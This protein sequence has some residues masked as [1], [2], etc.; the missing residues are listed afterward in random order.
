MD[1]RG[2][3]EAL[4][5]LIEQDR[6]RRCDELTT[7]A[8]LEAAQTLREARAQARARVL[9]ALAQERYRLQDCHT[10]CEAA[11]ATETRLHEQRRFRTLL[12][13]ARQRLPQALADRWANAAGRSTWLKHVIDCARAALPVGPWLIA[14]APGWPETER[15]TLAASLT[16]AGITATFREDGALAAGLEIRAAGNRIDGTAQGLMDDAG[17]IGAL[18]LDAIAAAGP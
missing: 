12:D 14:H 16:D 6:V 2:N 15:A 11:L 3:T 4:L 17:E 7:K 18:L 1:V 9:D 10:S 8:E 13:L 5:A